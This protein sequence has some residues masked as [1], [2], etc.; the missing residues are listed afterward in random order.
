MP[1]LSLYDHPA[2]ADAWHRVRSPGG[3]EWWYFDAEDTAAD[4]QAVVIL[5]EGFIFH[6]EY[7]RRWGRYA[8]NP[9][10]HAPPL[11]S[12][13]PCAYAAVY[14][15]GKLLAQSMTQYPAA[16]FSASADRPDLR[17]G[18]NAMTLAADGSYRVQTAAT[19]WELTWQ[20]P[21]LRVGDTLS[22]DLQFRPRGAGSPEREFFSRKL[23]GADHRWV[24]AAPLCEMSGTIHFAGRDIR[25]A[26]AGY[27]DHNFGT[28][29]IGPGL[30][31]WIWGRMLLDDRAVT[32]HFARA[33]DRSLP[34]EI[35]L[36]E[37]SGDGAVELPVKKASADWAGRSREWLNYPKSVR[38]DDLLALENPRIVDSSP[39]YMRL[40]YDA[41]WRGK[42][43]T[44]FC[45]IAYPHRLRWPVLG[46]MIEM[47]I[48]KTP[49]PSPSGR[50]IG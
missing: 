27:H 8:R 20:G 13:Y 44:S 7:L 40:I 50:G 31:R 39:F 33:K 2:H 42:K 6:S 17:I 26:G 34:D 15:K 16:D 11:P 23:A 19:P 35:H 1:T 14:E 36:I 25:I 5:F 30:H 18:P 4:I 46:R 48:N 24:I 49:V 43:G 22:V 38:F 28:G 32:F 45:E 10:R 47:S 9:T 3:Y 29:P 21:K 41:R 12:E 37:A